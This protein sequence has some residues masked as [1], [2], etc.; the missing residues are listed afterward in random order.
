ILLS[1]CA[2]RPACGSPAT[3]ASG[4]RRMTPRGGERSSATVSGVRRSRASPRARWRLALVGSGAVAL[5]AVLIPGF[6]LQGLSWGLAVMAGVFFV[7][8]CVLLGWAVWRVLMRHASPASPGRALAW[9]AMTAVAFSLTW[10]VVFSGLAY[11]VVR[12]GGLAAFLRSGALWQFVWGLVI[13]A[14]LAQAA[15]A[16]Q[17]LEEQERAAAG[18]ELQAL[19]AQLNPHFLFNTLHALSQLAREDP[20]ATQ[21]ALER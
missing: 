13:Y 7:A 21:D 12:P 5:L 17:R 18:A 8:P 16:Q 2:R 14:G 11:L 19:R 4:F 6:R 1:P 10:T 3:P 9:H 20:L 15:R